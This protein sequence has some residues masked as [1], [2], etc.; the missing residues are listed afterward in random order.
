MK[1]SE[2]LYDTVSRLDTLNTAKNG[3]SQAVIYGPV[4][5]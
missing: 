1:S 5:H 4:L 2:G 3:A